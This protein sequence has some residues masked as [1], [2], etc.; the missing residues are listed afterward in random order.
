[1]AKKQSEVQI[2][3][4]A[5]TDEFTQGIVDANKSIKLM[6]NELKL[7]SAQLK[8]NANDVDLLSDRQKILQNELAQAQ[9]KVDL[10]NQKLEEARGLLGENSK[11]YNDLANA[12]LR[13]QTQQVQIQNELSQTTRRLEEA[14][15]DTQEL[16]DNMDELG[17]NSEDAEDEVGGLA[18][19][20]NK[21]KGAGDSGAIGIVALGTAIGTLASDM[22]TGAIDKVKEF[23]GYLWELPEAT[24][25]FR[26]NVSKLTASTK[27][28]G[29]STDET[30]KLAREMYGYFGDE[31]VVANAISNL[32]GMGLSQ[33]N[34]NGMLN[35][36]VAVWSA[37]GDSIPIEGLTESLN[38]SAQV[39]KVTGSLADA[40]NWAS[41]SEDDFNKK[42][43]ACNSTKERAKL[44]E[45]TLSKAYG[46]SKKAYDESTESMRQNK[47]ANWDLQTA[48]AELATKIEPIQTKFT[49]LKTELLMRFMP[50]LEAICNAIDN[51]ITWF[52]GLDP[53]MQNTI[54]IVGA[55]AGAVLGL[56][57]V[58]GIL[59]LVG[60]GIVSGLGVVAGVIGSVLGFIFSIPGLI[61][62]TLVAIATAC[63]FY[64][65]EICNFIQQAITGLGNFMSW[66]WQGICTVIL[67]VCQGIW[68]VIVTIWNGIL[69]TIKTV[70]N[71]IKTIITTI[72]N[73]IKTVTST[74]WNGI[75]SVISTVWNAIRNVVSNSINKVA[76]TVSNVFNGIKNTVKSIWYSIGS[77]IQNV[78]NG[79]IRVINGMISAMNSV[80]FDVP[81]WVPYMGGKSFGFNLSKVSEVRWFAKG[82]IMTQP[83]LFGGGEAGAEAI[84]PLD[85]FYNY[86]DSKLNSIAQ[87]QEFDYEA[88]G[89][90]MAYAMS[91]VGIYMDG[92]SVG[93]ITSTSVEEETNIRKNI[94]KRLGGEFD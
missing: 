84:L 12:V 42:L 78:V 28:Y 88:M 90:A 20:L 29:Y 40:L 63:F 65:D 87:Q 38:E 44:I 68:N 75:K 82:G 25:E 47:M 35:A 56:V 62:I 59:G 93:R 53:S 72:W 81:D 11:E 49:I 39:G 43:E 19:I 57:G 26:T 60:G 48:E 34:L 36:G 73:V 70:I 54:L 32:Q 13:A 30:N 66:A 89:Q 21:L 69:N 4:K 58:I 37:Y 15:K 5:V 74:I 45:K 76:T 24:E 50:V 61:V 31:Q 17:D 3:F 52:D 22:I 85:G 27:N 64:W 2:R 23:I 18:G 7:N 10:T 33:S 92:S 9:Q 91:N 80:H 16:G 14:S 77:I 46:N 67:T 83:T 41:I 94:M 55:V 8:N 51:L 71:I 86:L 1:M 79:I 6:Q